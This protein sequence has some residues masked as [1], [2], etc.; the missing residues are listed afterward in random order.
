M[1]EAIK[2]VIIKNEKIYNVVKNYSPTKL[3]TNTHC[4]FE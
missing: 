2:N 3:L 1:I 4:N